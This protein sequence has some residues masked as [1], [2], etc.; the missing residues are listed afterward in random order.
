MVA[1]NKHQ[2]HIKPPVSYLRWAQA[3]GEVA[4]F[5]GDEAITTSPRTQVPGNLQIQLFH[6]SQALRRPARHRRPAARRPAARR[7]AAR[8]PAARCPAARHRRR[9]A[10]RCPAAR[11]RRRPAARCPAARHRRRQV[12]VLV[13]L[14]LRRPLYQHRRCLLRRVHRLQIRPR[15]HHLAQIALTQQVAK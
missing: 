5:L 13:A 10:A 12:L 4:P 8:R 3:L 15:R 6:H 2:Y 14:L 1:L 9:P 11:H 7:P